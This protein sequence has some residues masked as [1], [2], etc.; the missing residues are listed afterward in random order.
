MKEKK[1]KRKGTRLGRDKNVEKREEAW[2]TETEKNERNWE[3]ER[4]AQKNKAKTESWK[5]K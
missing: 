1:G 4:K 5:N 2:K 3:I